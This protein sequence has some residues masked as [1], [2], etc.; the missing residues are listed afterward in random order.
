MQF[1]TRSHFKM[2]NNIDK[3]KH[4]WIVPCISYQNDIFVMYI[5]DNT[6]TFKNKRFNDSISLINYVTLVAINNVVLQGNAI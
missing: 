1:E 4:F 2:I 6:Q 3:N 5:L